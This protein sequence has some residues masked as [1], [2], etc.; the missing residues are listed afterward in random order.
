MA[1]GI[2]H[3]RVELILT[4]YT[5]PRMMRRS[6]AIG[7]VKHVNHRVPRFRLVCL[8]NEL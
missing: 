2:G 8:S 7:L 4:I 1:F 5:L 6:A 3:V